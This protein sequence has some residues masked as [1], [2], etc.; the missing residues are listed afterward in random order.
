MA[1]GRIDG[2]AMNGVKNRWTQR[3]I[4]GV[5]MGVAALLLQPLDMSAVHAA[6]VDALLL[7]AAPAPATAA[8]PAAAPV[9]GD[10]RYGLFN[11]L[12]HRSRYGT[13]W[14][15]EPFR[16]GEM[17]LDNEI[18]VDWEHT[19]GKGLIADEV[20]AEFEKSF[21]LLTLEIEVPYA[22]ER[23]QEF[24]AGLGQ[25]VTMR[26]EGLGNIEI[27]ARHPVY[28]WVSAD[29]FI[30]NTFGVSFELAVPTNTK[31]S[32]NTEVV[33]AIFDTLR[34]GE[35]FSI[36]ASAGFSFL[37]GPH[38]D[39]GERVFEYGV[40]FGYSF[41]HEELPLPGVERVIPILELK[42]ETLLNGEE[43]GNNVLTGTAG[44]RFN[45][46]SIGEFQPRLGVGYIFPIDQ[47]ARDEFRWG[48]I[49]SLV[50][51]F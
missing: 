47:G 8:A 44:V 29:D 34:L 25:T 35:H 3:W 40:V 4:G 19:E 32:K 16:V 45:L 36:Q 20:K 42:G 14:F 37:L 1:G 51:E 17:D 22:N 30:D 11:M 50:F 33:P 21:G 15:P 41:E 43:S 9:P 5:A 23:T 46:S 6:D 18:R 27:A 7:A 12:D 26:E 48:I 2:G 31:V 10:S 39:G 38:P 24:D 28:Q 49:T 13:S